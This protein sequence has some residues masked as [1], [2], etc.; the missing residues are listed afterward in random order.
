MDKIDVPNIMESMKNRNKT[1]II[2]III[3]SVIGFL[4]IFFTV[5]FYIAYVRNPNILANLSGEYLQHATKYSN[6]AIEATNMS[7]SSPVSSPV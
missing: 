4:A 2:C 5:V 1:G 7:D 6:L 3:F